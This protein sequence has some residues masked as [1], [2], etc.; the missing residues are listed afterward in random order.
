[1]SLSRLARFRSS[2]QFRL[3]LIF[4]ILTA[5]ISFLFCTLYIFSEIREKRA[6]ANYE[7]RLMARH[8]ASSIR[9]P[10]YAENREV[11][12]QQAEESMRFSDLEAVQITST[13]GR[14]LLDLH[15][16]DFFR[17]PETISQTVEV[18]SMPLGMALETAIADDKGAS[19]A[20][21]G[22]VRLYKSTA[23]LSRKI[24]RV[25]LLSFAL[26]AGFWLV[27]SYLCHLVLRQVTR[28]FNALMRGV[29]SMQQ[30][31]YLSRIEVF[32]D[33][34]PAKAA[35]AI[36]QLA[37]SLKQRDEENRLLNEGLIEA[38]QMEVR[39]KDALVEV[40][41]SLETEIDER[42]KAEQSV[43]ESEQT[44]RSL[45]D[46]MPVGVAWTDLEGRIEYLNHFFVET[47]GYDR[48]DIKT[49]D[50]WFHL[51]YPDP[52]YR[53]QME[54]TSREIIGLAQSG[55]ADRSESFRYEGRITCKD[56]TVRHI[57]F[58]HQFSSNRL[59][60]VMFDITDRELLQ[61]KIARN[62]KLESLAVLAGGIAHNFNNVLTGIMGYIS[63]AR[64]FLDES[65]KTYTL[66]GHAEAASKRA[67]GMANQLLTFARGG[68]MVLKP[69]LVRKLIDECVS[70]SL[71][72]SDVHCL[73]ETAVDLHAVKGDEGQLS[74][75]FTNIII[76][77][78]Q[79]MPN[80]GKL[81]IRAENVAM[82][83]TRHASPTYVNYVRLTFSDEG[84][85]IDQDD[86]GRIFDPYF[87][88]KPA[89]TGLGL[90]SVY[91]IVQKHGG[92]IHVDSTRGQGTTFT[93]SLPAAGRV[94]PAESDSARD[95]LSSPGKAGGA[96]LIMD[97]EEMIR[98]LTKETLGFLGYT[99]VSCAN[100][101]EAVELYRKAYE[102]GSPFFAVILDLTVS[103]GMGG[104]EAAQAILAIDAEAKLVVSSGY[105]HHPVMAEYEEHGF[106]AA[107]TKP[108][109]A[110]E[111]CRELNRL[112]YL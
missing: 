86:L 8:L 71:N 78:A 15:S 108:Y 30:G 21:L 12:R 69:V 16:P 3:F 33:D 2:F 68:A 72:R 59:I 112:Q 77:A 82:P 4:T 85:G 110:D 92:Q 58:R 102:A 74:Q 20:L 73:V 97:D 32:S 89:G 60:T 80:G 64:K 83:G 57:I 70:L 54:T 5:L 36:N 27:V 91:S 96:I 93:L 11:L 35:I 44:L 17:S 26:A 34:E 95:H 81:I 62:Q 105:F 87:T 61:E 7:L 104:K 76:N 65:H 25:T 41:R 22:T 9:L 98:G 56:G 31:D 109:K 14:I 55:E 63:Y 103:N 23:D 66:L 40:N 24:L 52:A 99:V 19:G 37:E 67:A 107:V 45:M 75:V 13:D 28:S 53:L 79:A 50:D 94:R 6:S 49:F 88:T 84:V 29:E 10:M 111:L 42:I 1:M 100:G 90:A 46:F 38:V 51:A 47:F 101:E 39:S 43:R 106:I 18:R 48:Q